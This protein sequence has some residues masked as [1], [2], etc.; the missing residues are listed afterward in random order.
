[1]PDDRPAIAEHGL[2]GAL[3]TRALVGTNGAINPDRAL[4]EGRP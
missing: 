2:S 3:R 1:M 4:E